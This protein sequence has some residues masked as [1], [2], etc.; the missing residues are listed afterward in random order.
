MGGNAQPPRGTEGQLQASA[1]NML[2]HYPHASYARGLQHAGAES[3]SEDK[4]NEYDLA[5]ALRAVTSF[6]G[7]V[8]LRSYPVK[9]PDCPKLF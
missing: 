3:V 4:T 1:P 2:L 9:K 8:F 6:W 5:F 7:N